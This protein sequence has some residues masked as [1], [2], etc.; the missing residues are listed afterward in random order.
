MGLVRQ[1]PNLRYAFRVVSPEKEYVL[2]VRAGGEA[3]GAK[4]VYAAVEGGWV[5]REGQVQVPIV[6]CRIADGLPL[7]MLACLPTAPASHRRAPAAG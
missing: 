7:A 5:G 6:V 4:R 3:R 1:D 2:Q